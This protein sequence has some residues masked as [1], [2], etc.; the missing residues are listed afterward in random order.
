MADD[1]KDPT[2]ETPPENALVPADSTDG[3]DAT[4]AIA[5]NPATA[6]KDKLQQEIEIRDVGPCKKHIKVIVNRAQIDERLNERYTELVR[7]DQPQVRGFRPGKAPRKLI[8][9]QYHDS[10]SEEVKTQ[11]LMAS[12][13]QLADEQRISPLSPPDLDPHAIIIPKEGPFIY[14][15]DIEV[16]PE[17]DVPNYKGLHLK[18]PVHTFTD[19][20]I[21]AEKKRLLEPYGQLVPKEGDPPTVALN[22]Y[23]TADVVIS[24]H[25]KEINKLQETRVKVE[26]QFALSDGVAPDFGA[27]MIGAKPGDVREVEIILSQ[28][29]GAAQLRGQK[30]Q[31]TFTIKDIKE[32]RLPEL[33]QEL[34]EEVFG[35]SNSESLH[36]FVKIVLERRL[37]YTQR[38]EARAEVLAKLAAEANWDLPQDMLRRQA[39]RTLS[40]RLLEMK[41]AG[42]SEEQIAGRRRLL[43]QDVLKNTAAALKEH[44]V[45]QKIAELEKIEIEDEDIDQEIERIADRAGESFRKVKARM[46]KEDMLETIAADLL[47]RKS[48]DLILNDAIYEDYEWNAAEESGEVATVTADAIPESEAKAEESPAEEKP[49]EAPPSGS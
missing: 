22:D 29:I 20:E 8:E 28:E 18:R 34:M 26:K 31:A 12:L 30:V 33:T 38:Q 45:L 10:V 21:E 19:V 14:E 37:E 44:F 48:L 9:K 7:S 2:P 5:E 43:E 11:V 46:E 17:F 4:T 6:G 41:N 47:E 1:T 16:R 23:I 32:T 24:F 40:R 35:V 42:M 27:K 39:S 49:A 36:E 15:F 13:E 25:G 3:G